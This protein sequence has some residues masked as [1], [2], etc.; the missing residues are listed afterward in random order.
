[1]DQINNFKKVKK[2]HTMVQIQQEH[3]KQDNQHSLERGKKFEMELTQRFSQSFKE[4]EEKLKKKG[5]TENEINNIIE[6]ISNEF[7]GN[8][9]DKE[10]ATNLSKELL[11]IWTWFFDKL[12]EESLK[13]FVDYLK[14]E[15]S[16]VVG[17]KA[18]VEDI[19][20]GKVGK[21]AKEHLEKIGV[22]EFQQGS[23]ENFKEERFWEVYTMHKIYHL[24]IFMKNI[25]MFIGF[26]IQ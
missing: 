7:F 3:Q 8:F 19:F 20:S 4:L 5:L 15:N 21:K 6:R 17:S 10:K 12:G 2:N 1:M 9:D 23:A 26:T 11:M 16:N 14:N 22:T 13:S 18:F 24:R 25:K